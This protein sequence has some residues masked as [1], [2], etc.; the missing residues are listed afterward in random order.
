MLKKRIIP[1]VLIDGFSVLKTVSFS[2]RR[3]L[4]S[5]I[6]TLKTY[7]ARNVDELIILD[8]DASKRGE[9]IDHFV[10]REISEECFMPLTVGGGIRTCSDIS[11]LLKNG[12]DKVAVNTATIN[13]RS[14][15]NEAVQSFGSQCI[16]AS[17][18]FLEE[19]G[20]Y[21]IYN[22]LSNGGPLK[23]IDWMSH[24][25]QDGVGEILLTDVIRDGTREGLN[26]DAIKK[27]SQ[28]S[29]V[30]LIVAGGAKDAQDVAK[31][32]ALEHVDAVGASSIFHFSDIT[33]LKCRLEA[34]MIGVPVR[35][36][37]DYD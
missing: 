5:P 10:I 8:I 37:Y 33:P 9:S 7:N 32:L 31:T 29:N 2:Q 25:Q 34:A 4:G 27:M 36:D 14:F 13:E 24:V 23:V 11:K 28:H 17:A 26:S 35:E 19:N 20:E 1:I 21:Y 12:A 16:V 6:T 18:D 30:P 3:N 22:P 15:L